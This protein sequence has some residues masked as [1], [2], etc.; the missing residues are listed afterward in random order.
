MHATLH[1]NLFYLPAVD[2]IMRSRFAPLGAANWRYVGDIL[3]A[4]QALTLVDASFVLTDS[5]AHAPNVLD[6]GGVQIK[7]GKPLPQVMDLFI[8]PE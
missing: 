5:I 4:Q 7:P 2:K 1:Q 6:I 8:L 3:H